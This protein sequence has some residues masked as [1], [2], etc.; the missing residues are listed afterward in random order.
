[1]GGEERGGSSSSQNAKTIARIIEGA[2][3]SVEIRF[4]DGSSFFVRARDLNYAAGDEVSEDEARELEILSS[5]PAAKAKALDLLAVRDHSRR[6]LTLK[7]RKREFNE[8]AISVVLDELEES[9]LMDD[10]RYAERWVEER[11]RR[12]PESR[13]HLSRRLLQKGIS[14]EVA[15]EVVSRITDD[16]TEREALE[17]AAKRL[18]R[19]SRM[20]P[21]RFVRSLAARGFSVAR[22]LELK[23]KFFPDDA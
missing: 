16:N 19:K 20:N 5:V 10:R 14:R 13:E 8:Q 22:I 1:M 2:D 12:H 3:G 9:G 7:L 11:L 4:T 15:R 18:L 17:A 23:D 21:Q 6:E